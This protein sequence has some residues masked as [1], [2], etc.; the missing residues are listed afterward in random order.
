MFANHKACIKNLYKITLELPI[1]V[2]KIG[3]YFQT[4]LA[5]EDSIS[6]NT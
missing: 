4:L 2:G 5:F 6:L 3:Q 1:Y